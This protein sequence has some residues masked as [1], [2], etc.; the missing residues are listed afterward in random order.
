MKTRI[1]VEISCFGLFKEILGQNN[2]CCPLIGSIC[3]Y[4]ASRALYYVV[5]AYVF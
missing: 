4:V 2:G 1:N 3:Q 5:C